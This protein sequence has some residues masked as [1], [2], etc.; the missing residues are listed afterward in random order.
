MVS[1]SPIAEDDTGENGANG[2]GEDGAE[3]LLE[4]VAVPTTGTG[5]RTVDARARWGRFMSEK[6]RV[7][8][9][10]H[11]LID[12]QRTPYRYHP[13]GRQGRRPSGHRRR[14]QRRQGSARCSPCR[15]T[16]FRG[17]EAEIDQIMADKLNGNHSAIEK[18]WCRSNWWS[19]RQIA[20]R[21]DRRHSRPAR[22]LR[23][24]VGDFCG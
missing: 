7:E 10:R 20:G 5:T 6:Q 23:L 14:H 21:A 24:R 11:A 3:E 18:R 17:V 4:A 2:A 15:N 16:S 19:V 8:H 13:A 1:V 12:H 9:A 22:G